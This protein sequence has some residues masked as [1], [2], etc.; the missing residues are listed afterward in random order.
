MNYLLIAGDGEVIVYCIPRESK[1]ICDFVPQIKPG[2][3]LAWTVSDNALP[4][5]IDY[6]LES[7][8]VF[9]S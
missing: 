6:C 8:P 9:A 2:G 1:Y 7:L 3:S 5:D 4:A